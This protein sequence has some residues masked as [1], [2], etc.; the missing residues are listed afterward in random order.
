MS[1]WDN[2][3]YFSFVA[4][5]YFDNDLDTKSISKSR[6]IIILFLLTGERADENLVVRREKKEY[7][8]NLF[9]WSNFLTRVKYVCK[10]SFNNLKNGFRFLFFYLKCAHRLIFLD[11]KLMHVVYFW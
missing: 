3:Q 7:Q 6:I 5:I 9:A 1:R 11:L 10:N 8:H 2:S 4:N